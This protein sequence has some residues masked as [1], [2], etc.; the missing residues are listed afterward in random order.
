MDTARDARV[1]VLED[2][3]RRLNDVVSARRLKIHVEY[4]KLIE[5]LKIAGSLLYEVKYSYIDASA[6]AVHEATKSLVAAIDDFADVYNA[7]IESVGF[8]PKTGKERLALAEIDYALRIVKGIPTRLAEHDEDPAYAI[9]ILAVEV[10]QAHP[11]ENSKNLLS[12][13]CTDGS[14]IW[15][16]VTNISDVKPGVKLACGVLP[17]VEMMNVV[18]EAMFLGGEALQEATELGL[19]A[20]P[21]DSALDQARA[22]VMQIT[23]RMM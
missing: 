17:P 8:K 6:L 22:Q 18:S 16:I 19:L 15:H 14:R 9:D 21:P 7:A 10:S 5:A 13:R 23:K 12:C 3:L 2:A 4:G 1:L 20:N 11:V